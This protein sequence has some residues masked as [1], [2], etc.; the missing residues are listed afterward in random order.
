L[1]TLKLHNQCTPNLTDC[2]WTWKRGMI[3][4]DTNLALGVNAYGGAAN[5]T[6]L[7]LHNQCNAT[8]AD[9]NF[10]ARFGAN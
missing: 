5:L 7:K 3:S 9:C 6:T 1:T 2:T 10:F 8:L 4:S